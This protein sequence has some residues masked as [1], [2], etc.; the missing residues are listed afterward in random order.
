MFED[1]SFTAV[2]CV[3]H[4]PVILASLKQFS[5]RSGLLWHASASAAGKIGTTNRIECLSYWGTFSFELQDVC[6]IFFL[7][8]GLVIYIGTST[9]AKNLF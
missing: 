5:E 4:V 2:S 3:E 6:R 9:N 1:D 7:G 8:R